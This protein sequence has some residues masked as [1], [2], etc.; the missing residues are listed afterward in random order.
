ME[1]TAPKK[2][3]YF[4]WDWQACEPADAMCLGRYHTGFWV[5]VF[6]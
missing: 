3:S 2:G 6:K 1:E 5:E 4:N